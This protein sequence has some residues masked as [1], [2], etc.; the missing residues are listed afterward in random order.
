MA[1]TLRHYPLAS[2]VFN[3]THLNEN[4]ADIQNKF[5]SIDNSDVASDAAIAVTKLAAANAEW[6]AQLIVNGAM[7]AA[8]WPAVSATTPLIAVPMPGQSGDTSW[9]ATDVTWVCNDVGAGTGLF[10]VRYGSFD[11]AGAWV[12]A[13]TLVTAV[14]IDDVAANTGNEGRSSRLAV[15]IPNGAD[16]TS[17]ALMS[18]GVDATALSTAQGFLSVSVRLRRVLQSI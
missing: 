5:G 18:G 7:L 1:L 16:V 17:I 13:G 14:T 6:T 10:D 15:S 8:G 3:L 11:G 2:G 4:L 12:D 9:I